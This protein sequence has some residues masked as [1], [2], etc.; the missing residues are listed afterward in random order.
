MWYNF[1]PSTGFQF[2]PFQDD[3]FESVIVCHRDPEEART[4]IIFHVFPNLD[5]YRTKDVWRENTDPGKKGLWLYCGR[6][7]GRFC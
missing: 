7:D 4:Q 1:D 2:W 3:L 6:T 5:V